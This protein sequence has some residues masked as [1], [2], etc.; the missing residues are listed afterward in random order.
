[1]ER[2]NCWVYPGKKDIMLISDEE[3]VDQMTVPHDFICKLVGNNETGCWSIEVHPSDKS[4]WNELL[5]MYDNK[6][7]IR[8]PD[9]SGLSISPQYH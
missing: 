9:G 3:V 1:M 2:I 5:K 4:R 8:M 6:I 7:Y